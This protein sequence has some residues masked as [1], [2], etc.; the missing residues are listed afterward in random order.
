MLRRLLLVAVAL[1]V[2]AVAAVYFWAD[3][4]L[5]SD[6]VRTALESQISRSIGQPVHIGASRGTIFPRVTVTLDNVRIG[7]P[8]RVTARSLH[9]GA[10]LGALFS[11]RIEHG[12]VR[13]DGARLQLPLPAAALAALSGG[14]GSTPTSG[15]ALEIASIDEVELS[16]VTILSGGRTLHADID[17]VPDGPGLI[18]RRFA[19][20][21]DD[22]AVDVTGRMTSL[23]GLTGTLA[24]TGDTLDVPALLAFV[25]QF[26][27]SSG[28]AGQS[29]AASGAPASGGAATSSGSSPA[30]QTASS[31]SAP[32]GMK[33]DVNIN[34]NRAVVGDLALENVAGQAAVTA[35]AIDVAPMQFRVFG[36]D[37][38]GRLSLTLADL[39][40]FH[41]DAALSD[42]DVAA[43]MQFLGAEGAMTGSLDGEIDVRGTGLDAADVLHTARGSSRVDISDGMV[44][45]LGLVRTIVL[46]G[47]TRA[48]SQREAASGSLDEPFSRLG[49][50]FSI[51]G[52]RATT[53]DL[54]FESPDVLL[55]ATG[56]FGL[57][58]TDVSLKANLQLSKE[59]SDKAGRDLK[60]YTQQNGQITLPATISG[61]VGDLHVMLDLAGVAGRAIR[62]RATEEA[63]EAIKKGLGGLLGR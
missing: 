23:A 45:N 31:G 21:A 51:G 33:L 14:A 29:A 6:T 12:V 49:A 34:V 2:A 26:A 38:D 24:V 57:D 18:V 22:T 16:D 59:L 58:G 9:V 1:A 27:A 4:I 17:V 10:S 53:D 8:A 5:A 28:L 13:L 36:G 37:Y 32:T 46:A 39:P 47:S 11:R 50:T 48:D 43:A 56:G 63:G 20:K 42:I 44:K 60:R 62:N 55:S 35:H 7:E 41:L 61:S 25:D 40:E 3:S 54:H 52:G 30:G 19:L 15:G